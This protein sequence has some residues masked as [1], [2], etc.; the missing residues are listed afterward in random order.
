MLRSVVLL[1]FYNDH[2]FEMAIFSIFN[3]VA[4]ASVKSIDIRNNQN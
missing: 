3:I 4:K 2:L 1:T